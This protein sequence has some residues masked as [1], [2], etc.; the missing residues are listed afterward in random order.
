MRAL[1]NCSF[2]DP[3]LKVA[4]QLKVNYHV[5][6][7]YWIGYADDDS[8]RLVQQTFPA[9]VYHAYFDAWKGLFP[10]DFEEESWAYAPEPE[11]YR[12]Y[13]EYELQALQ[14]MDRMDFDQHSFSYAER[15]L[16]F[17]KFIRCW[18]FIIDHYGIDSLISPTI[19]HRSFDFP[20]YLVCRRKGLKMISFMS[21]PFMKSGRILALS[22]LYQ[23]PEL[24]KQVFDQKQE[25]G[26][27]Q[28]LSEDTQG[29]LS[30]IQ[31][32]YDAAK[33]ENFQEY[34]RYHKQ[35]PS[36]FLTGIKFI[37]EML[38]KHSPWL[39]QDG[40]LVNG[41]PSYHKTD[42][43][44]VEHSRS[45]LNLLSYIAK[46]NRR[47]N[48][49]KRLEKEY[50]KIAVKPDVTK[51]YVILALH[52][53]P[54]ATTAP[55]AGIFADQLY[56]L[57]L[58]SR[59]LPKGWLIY[60]KE[61]P[62]QF[63]PIAEGNTGRPLRFYRDAL[64]IPRVFFMPIDADPFVLID[65]ALA[66]FSVAGTIGWEGIVRGK[67]V[68]CF[69]PSWYEHYTPGVLRVKN[70]AD[71][72]SV[73]AFIE[74]YLYDEQALHRYLKTIEEQSLCAYFRR[75]LKKVLS[76]SEEECVASLQVSVARQLGLIK[77]S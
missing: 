43:Q 35:K 39:G 11:E 56:V 48:Y 42:K 38:G 3:W 73:P 6:P 18:T 16:L 53:Q 77:E 68:I 62:K 1:Y 52:Y 22:D 9:A 71:L 64:K 33:P 13:V 67:P 40:W 51:K 69:G 63:N 41:V 54:E 61:N 36:V 45:R 50:R 28:P 8:E 31:Q 24:I 57:E 19:P 66:V 4:E 7:V 2:A 14:L 76:I 44:N 70:G 25:S 27:R 49:L 29:Y 37:S 23:I 74:R 21:T 72:E 20:L 55:R 15:R 5:E 75:G 30:R 10:R 32:N 46:I 34:N 59:H 60:V 17:R 26:S 47:I 58:M 65:Q 12:C